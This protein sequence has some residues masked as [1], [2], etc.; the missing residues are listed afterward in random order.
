MAV[1]ASLLSSLI[2][3]SVIISATYAILGSGDKIYMDKLC[4]SVIQLDG[5]TKPGVSFSFTSSAK[6]KADTNCTLTF[7]TAQKNQNIIVTVEKLDISDF[8][9]VTCGDYLKIYDGKFGGTV[10]NKNAAEQC[11][12]STRYYVSTS[13]AVVFHFVSNKARESRGFKA[14]V[15]L[16]FP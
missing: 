4:Q 1:V 8:D 5:E 3:F 12:S 13:D 14:S 11:G 15:A 2:L 10:L 16:H 9:D 7:K 6:Y